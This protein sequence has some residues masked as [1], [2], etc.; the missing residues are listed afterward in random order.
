MM[1]INCMAVTKNPRIW[2]S[3]VRSV[4]PLRFTKRSHMIR[5][6]PTS[7]T[8]KFFVPKSGRTFHVIL[9]ELLVV[10]LFEVFFFVGGNAWNY[11]MANV[12]KVVYHAIQPYQ[13]TNQPVDS[14]VSWQ[15]YPSMDEMKVRTSDTW[16]PQKMVKKWETLHVNCLFFKRQPSNTSADLP[17]KVCQTWPQKSGF[18]PQSRLFVVLQFPGWQEI[19]P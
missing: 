8:S 11:N 2:V 9:R 16:S 3:E 13:P 18:E 7:G 4:S 5:M 17:R 10:F 6:S 19:I 15:S 1:F 14:V 12:A